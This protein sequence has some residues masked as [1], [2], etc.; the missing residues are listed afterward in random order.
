MQKGRQ[1]NKIMLLSER[2]VTLLLIRL[3]ETPDV[4]KFNDLSDTVTS[5]RTLTTLT[6][7]M[8]EEGVITKKLVSGSYLTTLLE[9]T[10]KGRMVAEK[11][12]EARDALQSP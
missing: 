7:R 9:L 5:F 8:I 12:K 10:P 3:L 4:I 11:L 6:D 1:K 2:Y